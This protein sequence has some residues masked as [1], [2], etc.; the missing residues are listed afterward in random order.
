MDTVPDVNELVSN[1]TLRKI[2]ETESLKSISSL[3][4]T[5]AIINLAPNLQKFQYT[6]KAI[7]LWAK[8]LIKIFTYIPINITFVNLSLKTL[9]EK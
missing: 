4:N 8:S 9:R 5:I 3:R 6:L 1:K 7:K 2:K